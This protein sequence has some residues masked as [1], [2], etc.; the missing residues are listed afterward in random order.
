MYVL[1]NYST[2]DQP[3]VLYILCNYSTIDQSTVL[4]IL[5]KYM[6][7]HTGIFCSVMKH[8]GLGASP[9]SYQWISHLDSAFGPM[10]FNYVVWVDEMLHLDQWHS[11]MWYGWMRC[12]IWTNGIQLCGMGGWDVASGPMAFKYVVWVD[13]MLHLESHPLDTVDGHLLMYGT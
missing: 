11:I 5:Y 10:A 12:C 1:Y 3:T 13:G 2:I 6:Y 4:Y 7:I 9:A 8:H